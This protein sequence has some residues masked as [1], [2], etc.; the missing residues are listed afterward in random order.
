MKGT[1]LSFEELESKLLSEPTLERGS[2]A[3]V[4]QVLRVEGRLG[5]FPADFKRYLMVFGWLAFRQYEIF[6]IGD[7]VPTYL[8]L[9]AVTLEERR[10]F[11]LP[12][13]FVAVM[14][15]GS[16]DLYCFDT[17]SSGEGECPIFLWDHEEREARS[18]GEGGPS[19]TAWLQS[20]LE[21][22]RG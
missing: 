5:Q 9:E 11:G 3:T 13:H 14:Y 12:Q 22:K 18:P 20:K 10:Q 17:R 6:G 2:A 8:D 21:P 15:T 16:G 7:G 19:F 4:E 1:T